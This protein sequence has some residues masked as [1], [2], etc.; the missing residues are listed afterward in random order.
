[1]KQPKLTFGE[2]WII[3]TMLA[4]III[5]LLINKFPIN[6]EM[7]QN[8]QVWEANC[9]CKCE[10]QEAKP[11]INLNWSQ[12][13]GTWINHTPFWINLSQEECRFCWS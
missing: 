13:K 8:K 3:I 10:S 5:F 12:P 2:V 11:C 9:N 1:M 7:K 4:I 6:I